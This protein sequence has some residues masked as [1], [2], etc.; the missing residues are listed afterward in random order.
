[1][2]VSC[3][4]HAKIVIPNDETGRKEKHMVGCSGTFIGDN[5][6]LTAGHCFS[7]EITE[8]WIRTPKGDS[9]RID[10]VTKIS[11]G[12]DLALLHI[13]GPKHVHAKLALHNP[14]RGEVVYN[15]GSP[16]FLEFLLSEGIVSATNVTVKEFKAHYLISTAMINPGS[17]GGGAFNDKG[18]L[19]G[20]NTMSVGGP[21]GWAG[22]TMTVDLDTIKEFLTRERG[23]R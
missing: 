14:Q 2:D 8:A 4:I 5:E 3:L 19:I 13:I 17:S 23:A 9:H 15:V 22:I 18:E 21:F 10:K 11:Y 16:F 12:Q 1:M 20:V 6:V 7:H